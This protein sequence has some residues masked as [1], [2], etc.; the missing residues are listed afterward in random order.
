VCF[1]N[2]IHQVHPKIETRLES[3]IILKCLG[4]IKP[5]GLNRITNS[6]TTPVI[7]NVDLDHFLQ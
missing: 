6:H 4:A 3:Q 7:S 1:W 5:K 2:N